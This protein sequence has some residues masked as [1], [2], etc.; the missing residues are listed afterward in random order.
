MSDTH[1]PS[2]S[3][4]IILVVFLL[5]LTW[6]GILLLGIAGYKLFQDM[7]HTIQAI[8]KEPIHVQPRT[9]DIP[10]YDAKFAALESQIATLGNAIQDIPTPERQIIVPHIEQQITPVTQPPK[11]PTSTRLPNQPESQSYIKALYALRD[12]RDHMRSSLPYQYALQAIS[13]ILEEF[14]EL[15]EPLLPFQHHAARGI[16]NR[17]QLQ[18]RFETLVEQ[19]KTTYKPQ[20]QTIE[21]DNPFLKLFSQHIRITKLAEKPKASNVDKALIAVQQHHFMDALEYLDTIEHKEHFSRWI[22]DATIALNLQ[23]W[24]HHLNTKLEQL[25]QL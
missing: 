10:N 7:Q 4:G 16:P 3:Y 15:S 11:P 24:S 5:L 25:R 23:Q 14:P 1:K 6:G 18:E 21:P 22:E 19:Y 17:Q 8:P 20:P 9:D 2:R 12:L 13:P